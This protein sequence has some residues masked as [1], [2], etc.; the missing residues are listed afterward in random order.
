MLVNRCKTFEEENKKLKNQVETL[1]KNKS[2]FNFSFFN[3]KH[4][5][6]IKPSNE[7]DNKILSM[8]SDDDKYVSFSSDNEKN[9]NVTE[10]EFLYFDDLHEKLDKE[11]IELKKIIKELKEKLDNN[12]NNDIVLKND[13]DEKQMIEKNYLFIENIS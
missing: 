7:E 8:S 2:F 3:K 9:E 4:D 5:E 11:N 6:D 10:Q 13:N 12:I 1:S